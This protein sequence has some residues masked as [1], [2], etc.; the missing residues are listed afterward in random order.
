MAIPV[1]LNG[2]V[3]SIPSPGDT[4]WGTTLDQYLQAIATGTL[5]LS[6]GTAT[7]TAD[8]DLGSSFG[9]LAAY[10]KSKTAS[11]AAAGLVRA[12]KTDT[13]S[14]RNNANAADLPLGIGTQD[15]LT[16]N[17]VD[18]TGNPMASYTASGT[19]LVN[20]TASIIQFNTIEFDTNSAVTTGAAW[21]FT[22]PAGK[23]GKYLI[24]TSVVP[25]G[26]IAAGVTSLQVYKNGSAFKTLWRSSGAVPSTTSLEGQAI[27]SLVATDFIDI[28]V[29]QNSGG[30][31]SLTATPAENFIS[32]ARLVA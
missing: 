17:S 24:A 11:I 27:L 22:V 4:G 1:T 2:T 29:T 16:F 14:W 31:M 21:K 12:A 19:S 30:A 9:P 13:V 23:S 7:L 15:Q 26:A 28:R 10:F 3:Y 6:G 25:S 32:I 20:A 18:I 5:Q 8:I